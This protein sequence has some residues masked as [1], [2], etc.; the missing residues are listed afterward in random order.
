MSFPT[1]YSGW[2]SYVRAW[3][4]TDDYS[5]AQ[6]GT[7]L[8]LAQVR[9]NTD[10]ASYFMEKQFTFTYFA[11]DVKQPIDLPLT[12]PD[13]GKIRL[14]SVDGIGSLDVMTVN[15]YQD[16]IQDLKNST[17]TPESYVIDSQKLYIWPWP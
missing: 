11:P 13:F 10:L 3:I 6:I 17:I 7:F 15:E 8:D 9:L 16:K 2:I 1:T 12:I 4:G 14:V 5:D